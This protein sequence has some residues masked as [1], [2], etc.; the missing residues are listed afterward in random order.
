MHAMMRLADRFLVLDHGRVLRVG[1]PREVVED[2][3]V[4]EAYLG[5]KWLARINA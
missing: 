1:A 3:A 4:I 2:P 5:R